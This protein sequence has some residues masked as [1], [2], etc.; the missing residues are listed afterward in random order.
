[1]EPISTTQSRLL[2]R[3]L[4]V[5]LLAYAVVIAVSTLLSIANGSV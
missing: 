3:V 2:F 1:M 5:S 4:Q